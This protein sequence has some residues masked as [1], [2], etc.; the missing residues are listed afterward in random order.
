MTT[1]MLHL[2]HHHQFTIPAD[3]IT[4]QLP[5]E[6]SIGTPMGIPNVMRAAI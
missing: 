4:T 5:V 6:Q 3:I 1:Q 2:P